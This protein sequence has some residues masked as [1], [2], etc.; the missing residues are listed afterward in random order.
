MN[1]MAP[2]T[3]TCGELTAEIGTVEVPFRPKLVDSSMPA[4]FYSDKVTVKVTAEVDTVKFG[5]NLA[6][7]LRQA[8]DIFESAE[9]FLTTE[10]SDRA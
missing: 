6:A 4:D 5:R 10:G 1:A 7:L 2:V 9:P 8:A 3:L